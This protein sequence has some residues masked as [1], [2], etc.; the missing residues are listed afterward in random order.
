MAYKESLEKVLK[1]EGGY[2]NDPLDRGAETYKGISRRFYGAWS[3]W[4]IVDKYKSYP[5]VDLNKI[6]KQDEGLNKLVEDFYKTY[7]WDTMKLDNIKHPLVADLMF[8]FGINMGKTSIIKFVQRVLGISI[9]GVIGNQTISAINNASEKELAYGLL[10]ECVERYSYIINK[11][12]TQ[13]RFIK[14]WLNRVVHSYYEV[15]NTKG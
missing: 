1:H 2:V 10:L 4:T 11:D 3:G 7:F 14:G 12:Q 13:I 15:L 9:D 6:L 5:N 8:N